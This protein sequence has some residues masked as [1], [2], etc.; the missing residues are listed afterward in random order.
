MK[1]APLKVS[2]PWY[3]RIVNDSTIDTQA[4]RAVPVE[5]TVEMELVELL[6]EGPQN[7]YRPYLHMRGELIQAVPVVELPYGV[8]ELAMRHGGGV[9]VDVFYD[10]NPRQLSDLVSKGY[11]TE[12][13]QVPAEMSGMPW[14]I[15]G[16]ADFLVV[17]PEYADQ[18]PVVFMNVHDQSELS[19]D[20]ANSGYDLSEYF[21]D[22]TVEAL[23]RE[24]VERVD[25]TLV[26]D[27]SGQDMFADVVFDVSRPYDD[28][29]PRPVENV[30][31]RAAVPSG[32]FSRLVSEIAARR[33]V[34]PVEIVDELPA[35]TVPGSAEE[36]YLSHVSPGVDQVLSAE[37][38]D[39]V[40]QAPNGEIYDP[41]A[42]SE[43]VAEVL[44]AEPEPEFGFLDV[45][46]PDEDL[47][48]PRMFSRAGV[49]TSDDESNTDISSQRKAA[50]S[51]A[52]RIAA[53]LSD[54]EVSDKDES[55]PTL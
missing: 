38:I 23:E 48:P 33:R 6:H 17:A 43:V 22:F 8:T 42:E 18:P 47:T 34:E 24:G 16:K 46:Q 27:G 30:D 25:G 31:E 40:L 44:A 35:A 1:I 19:L 41:V 14:Q 7:N 53:E 2:D 51:R 32:V 10:F 36:L 55:Q 50:A 54:D 28:L 15:P 21:P 39:E 5:A 37:P 3:G 45:S 11:F 13:F 49:A 26:R 29:A 12:D 9:N 52:A 4:L 20:E